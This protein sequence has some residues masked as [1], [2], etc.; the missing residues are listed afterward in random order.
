M[1]DVIRQVATASGASVTADGDVTGTITLVLPNTTVKE[2]LDRICQ[3]KGYAWWRDEAGGYVI[4]AQPRKADSQPVPALAH[5][6]GE[7][8]RMQKLQFMNAQFLVYQLGPQR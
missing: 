8:T 3:A 4:S 1:A 7:V 6:R 2:V 5:G